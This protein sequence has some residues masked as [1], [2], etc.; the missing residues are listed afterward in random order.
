ML[1]KPPKHG[2]P[3]AQKRPHPQE[4]ADYVV[5][6]DGFN[7]CETYKEIRENGEFVLKKFDVEWEKKNYQ[8]GSIIE[9]VAKMPSGNY[10]SVQR[11]YHS[12]NNGWLLRC[13]VMTAQEVDSHILLLAD[14]NIICQ[15]A[16]KH[17]I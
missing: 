3:L 2:L 16:H 14:I 5:A 11:L 7:P 15:N 1:N 12:V 13:K 9:G 10:L 17:G 4:W 8:T 6:I